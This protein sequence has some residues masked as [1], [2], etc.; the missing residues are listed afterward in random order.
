MAPQ[1]STSAHYSSLIPRGGSCP[2][3]GEYILWGDIVRGCY[4]RRSRG[5]TVVAEDEDFGADAFSLTSSDDV[6]TSAAREESVITKPKRGRPRKLVS[7]PQGTNTGLGVDAPPPKRK[8]G[9]KRVT[10]ACQKRTTPR[11]RR[12]AKLM[13]R[14]PNRNNPKVSSQVGATCLSSTHW[15]NTHKAGS[16]PLQMTPESEQEEIIFPSEI[17]S[18]VSDSNTNAEL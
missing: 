6:S 14:A 15:S 13:L 17:A 10:Q 2:S 9:Q 8:I 1:P 4:R 5:A 12:P 11:A 7:L 16:F 18:D 3:C